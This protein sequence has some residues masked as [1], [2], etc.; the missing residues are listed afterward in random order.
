M[1]FSIE[2]EELESILGGV[3]NTI[4][5]IKSIYDDKLDTWAKDFEENLSS[6]DKE[7]IKRLLLNLKDVL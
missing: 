7:T 5:L 1:Q 2:R 4:F 6:E 3:G